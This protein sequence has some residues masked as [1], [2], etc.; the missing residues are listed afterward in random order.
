[1]LSMNGKVFEALLTDLSKAFD[2]VCHDLLIAKLN[3]YGLSLSALKLAHNYLQIR[4]QRTKNGI[5][6]SLWKEIVSGVPQWLILDPLMF[7]IFLCDLFLRTE[8]NYF[9]NYTNYTTP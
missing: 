1:M 5:A 7:N 4:K 3:T 8:S 2:C 9:T 6:Y